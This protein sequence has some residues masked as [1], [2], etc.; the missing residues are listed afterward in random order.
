MHVFAGLVKVGHG[1]AG[2]D[3]E[4]AIHVDGCDGWVEEDTVVERELGGVDYL[5][6]VLSQNCEGECCQQRGGECAAHGVVGREY[7]MGGG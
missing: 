2:E 3:I 7:R 6:F 5:G 4:G 1:E